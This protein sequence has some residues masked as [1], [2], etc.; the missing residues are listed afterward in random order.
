MNTC[1]LISRTRVCPDFSRIQTVGVI[2]YRIKMVDDTDN[3]KELE[4]P[5]QPCKRW[6]TGHS[7]TETCY[8]S[9]KTSNN[10]QTESLFIHLLTSCCLLNCP[11]QFAFSLQTVDNYTYRYVACITIG[12]ISTS[13]SLC[14]GEREG[15]F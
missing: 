8:I 14:L 7:R 2:H 1:Y 11:Q 5:L 9:L 13:Q 10:A 6:G 15:T 12:Y 3:K 4:M